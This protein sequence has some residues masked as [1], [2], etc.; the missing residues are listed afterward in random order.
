MRTRRVLLVVALVAFAACRPAP[1]VVHRLFA[2]NVDRTLRWEC[3]VPG[4]VYVNDVGRSELPA[5]LQ[6]QCSPISPVTP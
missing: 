1:L 4:P 2:P 5:L 6:A 3:H